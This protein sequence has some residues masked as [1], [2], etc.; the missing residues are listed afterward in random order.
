MPWI[1]SAWPILYTTDDAEIVIKLKDTASC[2]NRKAN[3]NIE[4]K[5]FVG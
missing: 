5:F 1:G 2:G 4:L 3:K